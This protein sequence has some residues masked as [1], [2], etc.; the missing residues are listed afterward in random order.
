MLFTSLFF[1][2]TRTFVDRND[3]TSIIILLSNENE[4]SKPLS[5]SLCFQM[6]RG[7]QPDEGCSATS[8]A[9]P[10]GTGPRGGGLRSAHWLDATTGGD[11]GRMARSWSVIPP[12][13]LR[14]P[15]PGLLLLWFVFT[16]RQ[17]EPAF[18]LFEARAS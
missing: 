12:C 6:D 10:S 4:N 18:S 2:K 13:P 17:K 3:T 8:V 7:H 16:G 11:S 15:G 5:V 9:L 14:S 1:K